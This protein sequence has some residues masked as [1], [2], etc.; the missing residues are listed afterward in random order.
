MA[1][2]LSIPF[3]TIRLRLLSGGFILSPLMDSESLF[4]N[5]LP[6]LLAGRYAEAFQQKVLNKGS[7]LSLL[8]E[9]LGGDYYRGQLDLDF[10][11][12]RSPV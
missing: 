4:V 6:E 10:P 3:F 11:D 9:Y 2:Q 8:D 5:Q 1:F 12:V 7:Y